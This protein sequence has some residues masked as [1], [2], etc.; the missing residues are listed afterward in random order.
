MA[1]VDR[2]LQIIEE[3]EVLAMKSSKEEEK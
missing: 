3:T 2:T 1:G